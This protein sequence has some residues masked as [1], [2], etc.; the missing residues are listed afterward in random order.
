MILHGNDRRRSERPGKKSVDFPFTVPSWTGSVRKQ[1]TLSAYGIFSVFRLVNGARDSHL[2]KMI[3]FASAAFDLY[4]GWKD[5]CQ[6]TPTGT[7]YFTQVFGW[8]SGIS[9]FF[10]FS[11]TYPVA[12]DI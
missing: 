11:P 9:V 12:L 5:L 6:K 10:H 4:T 8:R 2:E 3:P 7:A 1:Y